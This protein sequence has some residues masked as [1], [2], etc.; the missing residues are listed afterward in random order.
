MRWE[1]EENTSVSVRYPNR[2]APVGS[3]AQARTP[4]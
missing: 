1:D 3:G 4:G 2:V